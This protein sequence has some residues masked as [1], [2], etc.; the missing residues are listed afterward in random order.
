MFAVSLVI[1]RLDF[2]IFVEVEDGFFVGSFGD[3]VFEDVLEVH[4]GLLEIKSTVNE[5]LAFFFA[6]VDWHN[7]LYFLCSIF[8]ILFQE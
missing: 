3:D 4:V 7:S 5:L 1:V 8:T 6:I 2:A